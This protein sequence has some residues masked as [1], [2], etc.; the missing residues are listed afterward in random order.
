MDSLDSKTQLRTYYVVHVR[1]KKPQLGYEI[2]YEP[3]LTLRT[4]SRKIHQTVEKDPH[5]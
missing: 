4:F 3:G 2:G 1:K 5:K